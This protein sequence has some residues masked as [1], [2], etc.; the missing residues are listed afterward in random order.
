MSEHTQAP[1]VW[2]KGRPEQY[3]LEWLDGADGTRILT[4]YGN[5]EMTPDKLLIAAAP[6]LLAACVAMDRGFRDTS[7]Y[8]YKRSL[9]AIDAIRAAIKQASEDLL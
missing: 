1:W 9:E 4:I 2:N 6:A 7:E 3:D 5:G 8:G